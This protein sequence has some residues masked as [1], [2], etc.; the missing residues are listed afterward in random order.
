M[1][2]PPPPPTHMASPAAPLAKAAK[3]SVTAPVPAARSEP[4]SN[5][6]LVLPS[7][8]P[9][10][11]NLAP[12]S[13]IS[14]HIPPISGTVTPSVVAACG[15]SDTALAAPAV[16][17]RPSS[18]TIVPPPAA[19]S[20]QKLPSS[21]IAKPSVVAAGKTSKTILAAP[22]TIPNFGIPKTLLEEYVRDASKS[23]ETEHQY[24]THQLDSQ[25]IFAGIFS[26]IVVQLIPQTYPLLQVPNPSTS[27]IA[28]NVGL[29]GSL[30]TSLCTAIMSLQCKAWLDGYQPYRLG[31]C[32][33]D[34]QDALIQA[35][36]IR[37]Y[38][39]GG[40]VKYKVL[41]AARSAGPTLIYASFVLFFLALIVFLLELHL[42]TALA[43]IVFLGLFLVG[44]GLTSVIPCFTT[45]APYKTPLSATLEALYRGARTGQIPNRQLSALAEIADV[46]QQRAQ[47]DT[48]ILTWLAT[49]ARRVEIQEEAEAHLLQDQKQLRVV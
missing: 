13:A 40:L 27:A 39:Y 42:P 35:C 16:L 19:V 38:R 4:P 37:Q 9:V 15:A 14:S 36:R 31:H 28:I 46:R 5:C 33:T 43:I 41:Y 12:P 7:T 2:M 45:E 17:P 23:D 18:K 8:P 49:S 20:A 25:L 1:S 32:D 44:H 29:F 22:H 24:F 21:G 47:I 10:K 34:S 48:E 11:A 6:A 30:I 3:P 26:A